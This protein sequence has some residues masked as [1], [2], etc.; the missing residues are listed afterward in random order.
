VPEKKEVVIPVTVVW[1]SKVK[2]TLERK[3]EEHRQ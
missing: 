2:S 3:N 1:R